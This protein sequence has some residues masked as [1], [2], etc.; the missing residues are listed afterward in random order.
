MTLHSEAGFPPLHLAFH[1]NAE[2]WRQNLIG[3]PQFGQQTKDG[4]TT[5]PDGW[6][7]KTGTYGAAN[8]VTVSTTITR[9]GGQSLHFTAQPNKTI[10]VVSEFTPMEVDDIVSASWV[11]RV[12]NNEAGD[13]VDAFVDFY[14]AD[15]TTLVSSLTLGG[16]GTEGAFTK[17]RSGFIRLSSVLIRYAQFRLRRT[18]GS[19]PNEDFYVDSVK[20]TKALSGFHVTASAQN[21]IASGVDVV[22]NLNDDSGTIEYDNGDVYNTGSDRYEAPVDGVVT[23]RA[24]VGLLGLTGS[25]EF[26]IALRINGTRQKASRKQVA[27]SGGTV[28]DVAAT[29]LL[30]EGDLVDVVLQHDG[31][32]AGINLETASS[33][34]FWSG[35]GITRED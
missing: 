12:D 16:A 33:I 21:N 8:G 29:F 11:G 30:D 27:V 15:K 19:A 14:R 17:S 23:F 7:V 25:E 13:N 31:P 20:L 10:E 18:T 22:V 1:E 5:P 6:S 3:N 34:T 26:D 32:G 28:A 24:Q 2:T 9:S 35:A 4:A